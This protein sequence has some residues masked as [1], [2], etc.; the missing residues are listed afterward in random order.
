M[1]DVPIPAGFCRVRVD[2][3]QEGTSKIYSFGFDADEF[4]VDDS[5]GDA[6]HDWLATGDFNSLLTDWLTVENMNIRTETTSVDRGVNIAGSRVEA[7]IN[8]PATAVLIEKKTASAGRSN[9]GRM[10]WPGCLAD[11]EVSNLGQIVGDAI[12]LI[13]AARISLLA[14]LEAPGGSSGM[15]IIHGPTLADPTEPYAVPTRVTSLTQ[16]SFIATQRRRLR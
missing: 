15:Y 10:Y 12:A 1:P 3:S 2:L 4:E 13:A 14:L 6:L 11:D 7:S 8:T 16:D 5:R 9:R